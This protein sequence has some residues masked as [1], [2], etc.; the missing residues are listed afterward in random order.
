MHTAPLTLEERRQNGDEMTELFI[1]HAAAAGAT[2]TA[3]D[4]AEL[5]RA[6]AEAY[7]AES[8]E[9]CASQRLGDLVADLYHCANGLATPAGML[10]AALMEL[11]ATVNTLPLLASMGEDGR[12]GILACALAAVLAYGESV[13]VCPHG[14]TDEAYMY[15]SDE[16]EEARF[17]E[18]R[19]Q[20]FNA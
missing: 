9:F 20:R 17:M 10:G 5:G 14:V 7:N 11:S 2:L 1:R 8:D 12:P 18:V 15:W 6:M 3:G 19:A 13:G 16:V 4:R